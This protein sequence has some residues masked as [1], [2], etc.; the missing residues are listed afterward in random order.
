MHQWTSWT[1]PFTPVYTDALRV[2]LLWIPEE[3]RSM[4]KR[5]F[6]SYWTPEQR[7]AAVNAE[8][9]LQLTHI[10]VC[11][12][13][14]LNVFIVKHF[15]SVNRLWPTAGWT[16]LVQRPGSRDSPSP[17]RQNSQKVNFTY[18]HSDSSLLGHGL[19]HPNEGNVVVQVVNRALQRE[20]RDWWKTQKSEKNREAE[21]RL[22]KEK[23]NNWG[24][25]EI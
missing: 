3:T 17:N 6:L 2:A 16:G 5:L 21:K 10:V 18:L 22:K 25:Q 4:F 9:T 7:T 13:V 1:R 24:H 19:V 23:K 20:A 11:W 14:F 15:A 12:L 8:P